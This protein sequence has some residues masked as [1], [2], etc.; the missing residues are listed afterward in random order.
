MEIMLQEIKWFRVK[1]GINKHEQI[2][3]TTTEIALARS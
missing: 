3:P 2:F 1:F